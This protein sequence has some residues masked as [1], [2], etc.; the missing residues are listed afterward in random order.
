MPQRKMMDSQA[1][2]SSNSPFDLLATPVKKWVWNQ[3]WT[4]LRDIQIEAISYLLSGGD[5]IISASTAGGKT[6]AAFLPLLSKVYSEGASGSFDILYISP[7]K[8][9][10]NDQFRRLEE[11]CEN[12]SLPVTK[13]HGD[14]AANVKQKALKSP[15]GVLLITPE[16][17]ESLLM[18]RGI[19][20]GRLFGGTQAVVIDELHAFMGTERGVQLRSLLNRLETLAGHQIDR[21]GLSA[22]LGDMAMA[23]VYLRSD[24]ASQVPIITE[25]SGGTEL[26]LQLRSYMQ[27]QPGND[28]NK[29]APSAECLIAEHIYDTVRGSDNLVFAGSK[30]N[31]ELYGATL[32]DLCDDKSL[33]NEFFIHHANISKSDREFLERRLKEGH[34]PTTAVCTST[35]ELGIDIGDVETIVQIGCS[36][37]VAALRQRMGRSGRRAGSPAILRAYHRSFEILDKAHMLD[38]IRPR[39]VQA[40]AE[41]ELLLAGVYEPPIS[42][43]L[44]LSTLVHQIMALIVERGGSDARELFGILCRSAPFDNISSS[45]FADVLRAMA[46]PESNLM[47]QAPDGTLLLGKEGERLTSNYRFYAVFE[48][49]EEFRVLVAGKDLGTLPVMGPT[50]KGMNIIFSGRRWQIIDVHLDDKVIEVKPAKGGS[51]PQFGGKGPSR[52]RIIDQKMREIYCDQTEYQYLDG[53]SSELLEEGRRSFHRY[54]LDQTYMLPQGD[55]VIIF[56]W[57]GSFMI[58]A[59]MMIFQHKRYQVEDED[60]ALSVKNISMQSAQALIDR[61]ACGE[62][63]D[64]EEMAYSIANKTMAQY[65]HYLTDELLVQQLAS[66]LPNANEFQQW[67]QHIL[68]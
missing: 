40:T 58:V 44:H 55:G 8:A 50:A 27:E 42:G 13:W 65:D 64:I 33:P 18:H 34:L 56:P 11:L 29:P 54:T 4:S 38:F 49:E 62:I 52:H 24:T 12:L 35:L 36:G 37:S 1:S 19:H 7:L 43:Q 23:A 66:V 25:T 17:L 28:E 20:I 48:S 67:A 10:I 63:P 22:T 60:Y 61:L 30:Q 41:I 59:L 57:A 47:E 16:S 5:L 3:G 46:Q 31:V 2:L 6:E 39:L 45:L 26:K 21:I 9:L 51:P 53:V 68:D 32:R 15:G 14:V